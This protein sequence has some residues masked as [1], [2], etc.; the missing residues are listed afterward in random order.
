MS[1]RF[2]FVAIVWALSAATSWSAG[3]D[4]EFEGPWFESG[5]AMAAELTKGLDAWFENDR[6]YLANL[7]KMEQELT[8]D[9]ASVPSETRTCFDRPRYIYPKTSKAEEDDEEDDAEDGEDDDEE[10][11]VKAKVAELRYVDLYDTPFSGTFHLSKSGNSKAV[12]FRAWIGRRYGV[13]VSEDDV[14][15]DDVKELAEK[16]PWPPPA[17]SEDEQDEWERFWGGSIEGVSDDL[18]LVLCVDVPMTHMPPLVN[19]NVWTFGSVAVSGTKKEVGERAIGD[20]RSNRNRAIVWNSSNDEHL[21]DGPVT[22][23]CYGKVLKP[24]DTIEP[25]IIFGEEK[26]SRMYTYYAANASYGAV[27]AS[28]FEGLLRDGK[29]MATRELRSYRD[30]FGRSDVVDLEFKKSNFVTLD[31]FELTS[32]L[33]KE[34]RVDHGDK[35]SRR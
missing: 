14:S 21:F 1:K 32:N 12:P 23:M 7:V 30:V 34:W 9:V 10:K 19:V 22:I 3:D 25:D 35:K 18:D 13:D 28:A 11:K 5:A 4:A 17:P 16:H 26:N 8:V 33:W 15:A 31:K 29:Y 24:K 2:A 27:R 20:L 6:S